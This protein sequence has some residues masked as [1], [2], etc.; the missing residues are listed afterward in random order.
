[1]NLSNAWQH[2]RAGG[3]AAARQVASSL[4]AID[5]KWRIQAGERRIRVWEPATSPSLRRARALALLVP[6]VASQVEILIKFG[7]IRL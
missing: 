2:G 3:G 4:G 1:M 7:E 6:N 5:K